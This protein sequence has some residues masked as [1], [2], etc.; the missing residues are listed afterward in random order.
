M[1]TI[2]LGNG[3]YL[4]RFD[5]GVDDFFYSR[6]GGLF[7]AE[8]FKAAVHR[9]W[10]NAIVLY[11]PNGCGKTHLVK[12]FFGDYMRL[13]PNRKAAMM[14]AERFVQELLQAIREKRQGAFYEKYGSC[15]LLILDDAFCLKGK[16]DTQ[17]RTGEI[18]QRIAASGGLA[19]IIFDEEV[20]PVYKEF[21]R[22]VEYG[23]EKSIACDL[24]LPD[25]GCRRAYA[26]SIVKAE[27]PALPEG[28]AERFAQ[29]L[30]TMSQ[31]RATMQKHALEDRIND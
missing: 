30:K 4:L 14:S 3:Q 23:I 17:R 1:E 24:S 11:G 5:C 6:P 31:I 18:F 9:H 29:E 13:Y 20:P 21:W 15:Q 28:L 10:V 19:V 22:A 26:R 7:A 27:M 8:A 2:E 16:A 25:E 12:G